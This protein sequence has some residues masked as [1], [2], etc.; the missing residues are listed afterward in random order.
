MSNNPQ[1]S[2]FRL[3][4]STEEELKGLNELVFKTKECLD[5]KYKPTGYNIGIN[6]GED[7][8]QT[9]FHIFFIPRYKGDVKIT[10]GV[11]VIPLKQ[12]Y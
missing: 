2:L 8:G 6:S 10:G 7:S 9:V 5:K 12:K 4:D 3:F 11:R 1:T